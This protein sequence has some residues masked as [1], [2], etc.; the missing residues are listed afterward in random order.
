MIE[1]VPLSPVPALVINPDVGVS[2]TR[3]RRQF[4]PAYKRQI[5]DAV[6]ACTQRGEIGALRRREAPGPPADAIRSARIARRAVGAPSPRLDA[7]R[8]AGRAL[9]GRPQ[10]V[11]A[12]HRPDTPV[13][14][15][16]RRDAVM[17]TLAWPA[18]LGHR[19]ALGTALGLSRATVYRAQRRA[20]RAETPAARRRPPARAL[21]ATERATVLDVLHTARFV[22]LA[23]AQVYATLLDEGT[24]LCAERTMYPVLAD[25]QEV[26]A[27]RAQRRH[28]VYTAPELLATGPNQLW[29][30]DTT[31]LRG[32]R[33]GVWFALYVVLDVFSRYVVGTMVAAR[34]AAVLAKQLLSSCAVRQGIPKGQLTVHAD[35]EKPMTAKPPAAN[36][37]RRRDARRRLR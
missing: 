1:D 10:K 8:G 4:P 33:P 30:W 18:A 23:P 25:A 9:G 19:R 20:R 24:Y 21:S 26:R 22:D 14:R 13:T 12:A 17:A 7:P 36:N 28:P 27:R 11:L 16:L 37:S 29:S 32:P 6:A 35:R 34:E 31:K 3:T 15:R 2:P 5:L